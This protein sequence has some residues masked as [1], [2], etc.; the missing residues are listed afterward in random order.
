MWNWLRRLL[1]IEVRGSW[2]GA[3]TWG[4]MN[5]GDWEEMSRVIP[6]EHLA[7]YASQYFDKWFDKERFDYENGGLEALQK[8]CGEHFD[9]W[10][11]YAKVLGVKE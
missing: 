10:F 3:K 4:E 2:T 11:D 6:S 8:H 1:S 9:K 7:E 5:D